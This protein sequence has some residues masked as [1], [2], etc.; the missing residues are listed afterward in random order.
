MMFA[1]PFAVGLCVLALL[2]T[3]TSS[4]CSLM[5][6]N[7]SPVNSAQFHCMDG[8][9]WMLSV[10]GNDWDCTYQRFIIYPSS[11]HT[12]SKE[13][14]MRC[15]TAYQFIQSLVSTVNIPMNPDQ[16]LPMVDFD[17]MQPAT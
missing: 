10:Y 12:R 4:P 11:G 15:D 9:T 6:S 3:V 5:S 1:I 13:S 7:G 14:K 8:S 17:N 2:G 16:F